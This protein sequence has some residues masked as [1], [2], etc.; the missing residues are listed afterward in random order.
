MGYQLTQVVLCD[1]HKMAVV[2]IVC[3]INPAF[4]FDL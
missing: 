1:E 4:L 3:L 2:V